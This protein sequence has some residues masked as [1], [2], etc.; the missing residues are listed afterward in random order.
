LGS[1]QRKTR[2][3]ERRAAVPT[4]SGRPPTRFRDGACHLAGSLST[5]ALPPDA[6]GREMAE[7]GVVETHPGGPAAFQTV[8]APW[9]FRPP[10]EEG[11][12][13][14]R[15]GVTRAS[16]SG[17]ARHPGRFTFRTSRG[18]R[19]RTTSGLDAVTPT[20]WSREA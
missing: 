11:G 14:E 3:P 20:S 4:R 12:R 13:L 16:L 19:T 5:S 10:C 7:D 8:T 9:R 18:I 17:R 15:H 6:H 1:G 2:L